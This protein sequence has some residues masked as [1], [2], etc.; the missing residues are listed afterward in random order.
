MPRHTN[1]NLTIEDDEGISDA[2]IS[3][4]RVQASNS[5]AASRKHM[6]KNVHVNCHNKAGYTAVKS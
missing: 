1:I 5:E 4:M 3:M 2:A 6:N